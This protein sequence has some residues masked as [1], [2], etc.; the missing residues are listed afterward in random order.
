MKRNNFITVDHCVAQK[1]GLDS[2]DMDGEIVM[3]DIDK[4]K[5]YSFNQVGSRIWNL[6]E[7]PLAVSEIITTLLEEFNVDIETCEKAVLDFIN[8][9]YDEG[10]IY[11]NKNNL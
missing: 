10:I 9:A 4:G 7:N 6:I 11:V 5:Y 8:R 1:T 3:M 2:S